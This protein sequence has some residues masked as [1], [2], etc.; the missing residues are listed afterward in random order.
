MTSAAWQVVFGLVG[1][2]CL[3]MT[4]GDLRRGSTRLSGFAVSRARHPIVYWAVVLIMT[5]A[6]AGLIL[7]ALSEGRPG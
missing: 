7:G 6:G 4:L 5:L 1:L 3:V 2:L